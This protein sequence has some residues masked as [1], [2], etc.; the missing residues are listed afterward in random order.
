MLTI[1][2]FSIYNDPYIC[3][4]Y[5]SCLVSLLASSVTG[6]SFLLHIF[7]DSYAMRSDTFIYKNEIMP[8]SAYAF[9]SVRDC[10]I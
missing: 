10:D 9:I 5:G 6:Y 4:Q 3:V 8:V 1:M 7:H 2:I